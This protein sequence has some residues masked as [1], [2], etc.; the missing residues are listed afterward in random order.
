M[1]ERLTTLPSDRTADPLVL[2]W[3]VPGNPGGFLSFSNLDEWQKFICGLALH[4]A[5]PKIVSL[6]FQRAQNLYFLGWVD[7]D[8]IKVGE[9]VALTALELALKDRYGA[10]VKKKYGKLAFSNLLKYMTEEDSLTDD[11]IPIIRRCGG[12]AIGRINGET[13]PSLAEIRNGLAHGDP[14]DGLL[15]GGLLELARDLID[16]A[17]RGFNFGSSIP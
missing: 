6:K 12:S 15:Y 2:P 9:L 11:R 14:F 1:F 4:S 5:P 8:L 16:Y 10:G 3:P 7:I 13:K 17:Y